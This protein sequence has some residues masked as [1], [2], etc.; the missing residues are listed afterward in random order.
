MRIV[1]NL[2]YDLPYLS[3]ED[4]R[5]V[6]A[7]L[8]R[9]AHF[10][11]S[12][13]LPH[14]ASARRAGDPRI[15]ATFGARESST[16]LEVFVWPIGAATPIHDHTSW[17]VYQCVM[18]SLAEERYARLD[19]GEAAETARLRKLWQR[20]WT[21]QDPASMV[22]AYEGGIH[23][24]AN[25]GSTVAV[26]LHMYGPRVGPVDGRDYDPARD[27]VCNRIEDDV[28]ERSLAAWL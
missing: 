16:C 28:H 20:V 11:T 12:H 15:T 22:A 3:Q 5:R 4:A 23:R 8:G 27:F 26:S 7:H 14:V 9:D 17:G 25:A 10:V 21:P 13:I 19:D 1:N 24:I 18:G 6:L 2:W